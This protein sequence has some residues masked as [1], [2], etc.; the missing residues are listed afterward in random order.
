LQKW[1]ADGPMVAVKFGGGLEG[2][3]KC[4]H[5]NLYPIMERAAWVKT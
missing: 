5:P 4:N 3:L 1:V 2:T